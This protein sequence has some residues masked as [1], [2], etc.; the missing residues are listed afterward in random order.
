MQIV[1]ILD[2]PSQVVRA[3]LGG[4]PVRLMLRQFGQALYCDVYVADRL[5]IGGVIC[6]NDN[7][8]VRNSYLGFLGD[9]TFHDTQGQADP[10]SP[11]LGTRFVLAYISADELSA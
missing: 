11:G 6:Q 7:L 8:I 9:L 3:A 5:M 1:P 10:L 4:Q 2:E